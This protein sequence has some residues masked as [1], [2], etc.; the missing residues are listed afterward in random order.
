METVTRADIN[1]LAA[2]DLVLFNVLGAL[3]TAMNSPEL[4]AAIAQNL[5]QTASRLLQESNEDKL[6]RFLDLKDTVLELWGM[7]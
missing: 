6:Q 5:E 4:R 7:K 1:A 3:V 2:T